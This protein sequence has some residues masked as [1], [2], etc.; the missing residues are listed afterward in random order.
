VQ[1]NFSVLFDAI[2]QLNQGHCLPLNQALSCNAPKKVRPVAH[3]ERSSLQPEIPQD[4]GL[5]CQLILTLDESHAPF[6]QVKSLINQYKINEFIENHGELSRN[7]INVLYQSLDVFVFPSLCESFGFTLV[8][9]MYFGLPIIAADTASNREILGDQG[10]YFS[11][12]DSV[13]LTS[14]IRHVLSSK[15]N[16]DQAVDYSLQRKQH[17]C[18]KEAAKTLLSVINEQ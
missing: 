10:L 12:D 4:N 6:K 2:Q 14:Q 7:E 16:H 18:W 17:Y 9:A 5:S 13:D 15:K 1:K 8:E 11:A 3:C